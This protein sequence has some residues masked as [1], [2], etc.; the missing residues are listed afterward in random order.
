MSTG[1]VKA[2]DAGKGFGLITSDEA[3]RGLFILH[4]SDLFVESSAIAGEG[5]RSLAAGTK[6]SYEAMSSDK[7]PKAVKVQPV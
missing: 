5:V 3:A 4:S 6:V 1:T 2:F 7:G